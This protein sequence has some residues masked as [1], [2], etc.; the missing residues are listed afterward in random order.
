MASFTYLNQTISKY[1]LLTPNLHQNIIQNTNVFQC[2]NVFY[3]FCLTK[4]R[5]IYEIDTFSS[6][7]IIFPE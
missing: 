2:W 4:N 6:G 7:L 1:D 3:R 5:N